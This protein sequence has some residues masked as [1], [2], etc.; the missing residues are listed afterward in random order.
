[1]TFFSESVS[2]IR[3]V[4]VVLPEPVPPQIPIIIGRE[5]SGRIARSSCQ[6]GLAGSPLL[7]FPAL[8]LFYH[9]LGRGEAG[10]RNAERRGADVIHAHAMAELDAFGF[11]AVLAANSDLE[12]GACRA[13]TLDAPL[14][15]H[16][17]A[18]DVYGLE[19]VGREDG[20]FSLVHVF[21]KEAP[22]IVA[23]EAHGSLRQVVRTKGKELSDLGDFICEERCAR[24]LNHGAD[25]IVKFH[26]SFRNEVIGDAA[27]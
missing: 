10:N 27:R 1:M 25:E 26:F 3:L 18:R 5:F 21:W 9:G 14:N 11:S 17:D 12:L 2:M 15:Q 6:Q 13:P 19:W 4:M 16:A 22:G 24:E 20:G 23:G 7:F 8:L